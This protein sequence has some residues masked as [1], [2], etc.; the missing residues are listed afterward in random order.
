MIDTDKGPLVIWLRLAI[1][2][3]PDLTAETA[4]FDD[5]LKGVRLAARAPATET[6]A[7]DTK[8]DGT[9]TWTLTTQ[10]AAHDPSGP[11]TAENLATYPWVFT[12]VLDH[13]KGTLHIEFAQGAPEDHTSTFEV[14]D[15][16]IT[17]H[18]SGTK[19]TFSVVQ[20]SDGTLHLTAVGEI[21]PGDNYVTTTKP[22]TKKA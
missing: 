9:Y 13:G 5:F 12:S 10:D 19:Q 1:E 8:F 6:A 15:D 18:V 17:F 21:N 2:N 4:R 11:Q 16:Q 22:W 7:P 3:N 14:K 20:D